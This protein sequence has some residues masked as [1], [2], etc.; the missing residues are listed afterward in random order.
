MWTL[1]S[2]NYQQKD[3]LSL[4]AGPHWGC[5]GKNSRKTKLKPSPTPIPVIISSDRVERVFKEV[6]WRPVN[7]S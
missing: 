6:E 7:C 4:T 3:L 2:Q 5:D 1:L